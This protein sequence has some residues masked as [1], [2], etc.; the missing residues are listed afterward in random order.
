MDITRGT[1]WGLKDNTKVSVIPCIC[2]GK[3]KLSPIV[4]NKVRYQVCRSCS[5]KQLIG[6]RSRGWKG[7][8][9]TAKSGYVFVYIEKPSLFEQMLDKDGYILEHRLV[10][11]ESIGRPLASTEIVHHKN[12]VKDDNR[13]ENLEITSRKSHYKS[14]SD[15]FSEG[16]WEGFIKGWNCAYEYFLSPSD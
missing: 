15:G 3:E 8:R 6:K 4:N 16:Y 5:S 2:C 7:G 10:M 12:G 14:R 11:A 13:I 9:F 1:D